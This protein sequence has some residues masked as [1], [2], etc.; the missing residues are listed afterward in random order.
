MVHGGLT[1][2]DTPQILHQRGAGLP[3]DAHLQGGEAKVPC[4]GLLG[5]SEAQKHRGTW[6]VAH[7][8]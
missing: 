1:L 6:W 5:V 4:W 8:T 2:P 7:P 3:S